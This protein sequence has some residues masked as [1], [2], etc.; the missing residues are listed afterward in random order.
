LPY[1]KI[2]SHLY[3]ETNKVLEIYIILD[4]EIL[5]KGCLASSWVL[6][7]EKKIR[8]ARNGNRI[9]TTRFMKKERQFVPKE[10]SLRVLIRQS[11]N[12][13]FMGVRKG[14][15]QRCF[16]ALQSLPP[17]NTGLPDISG[18]TDFGGL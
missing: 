5:T 16:I 15:T 9:Q 12:I 1:L 14:V 18:K 3:L 13:L 17:L 6:I 10:H 2:R 11:L 7:E 8:L 4:I